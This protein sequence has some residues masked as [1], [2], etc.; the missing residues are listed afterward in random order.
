MMAHRVL[1]KRR[2]E[3]TDLES[4][5]ATAR[6]LV[7]LARQRGIDLDATRHDFAFFNAGRLIMLWRKEGKVH[8]N[9]QGPVRKLP[10]RYRAS[11]HAFHGMWTEAGTL[12]NLEEALEFLK[13]WLVD[14]KEV[15]D[16]PRRLVRREGIG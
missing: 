6:E 5:E 7:V 9:L 16:L 4:Q 10:E 2:L 14:R 13:A 12:T 3:M 1:E 11:A 15:D 8:Y